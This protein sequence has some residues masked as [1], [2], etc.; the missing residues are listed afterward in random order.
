MMHDQQLNKTNTIDIFVWM[1]QM[2]QMEDAESEITQK[3]GAF[4]EC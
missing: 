4:G 2:R 1:E 3:H